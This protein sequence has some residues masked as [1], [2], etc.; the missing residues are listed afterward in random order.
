MLRS[1]AAAAAAAAAGLA[2]A[3]AAASTGRIEAGA[4]AH[5]VTMQIAGFEPRALS[6][7]TGERITW[8]NKDLFPHTATADN[9]AFDSGSVAPDGSWTF[10]AAKPGTYTYTCAFHPTMKGT[11][12]VQ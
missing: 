4:T 1:C 8:V 10:V 6:V 9:K 3:G 7:K 2:L 5:V 11:I 12:Q